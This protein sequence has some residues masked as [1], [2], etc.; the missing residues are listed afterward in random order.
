M[1]EIRLWFMIS[2][3]RSEGERERAVADAGPP[4]A[5]GVSEKHSESV[6]VNTDVD[7]PALAAGERGTLAKDSGS[8]GTGWVVDRFGTRREGASEA[9]EASL[10]SVLDA[11]GMVGSRRGER[12]EK[13]DSMVF[14]SW[15]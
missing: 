14:S 2:E 6:L 8:R 4:A 5:S 12:G 1:A 3:V 13:G 10:R 11:A 7:A 9:T 15:L